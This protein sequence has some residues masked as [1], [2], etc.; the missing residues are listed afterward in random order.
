[1]YVADARGTRA[2]KLVQKKER[3]LKHLINVLR[4]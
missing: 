1:M 2:G 4:K 3:I